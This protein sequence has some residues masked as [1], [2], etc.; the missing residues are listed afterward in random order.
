MSPIMKIPAAIL[1]ALAVLCANQCA[2]E[3]LI[4]LRGARLE[5]V[6]KAGAIDDGILLIRDGKID[7]VGK[8]VKIPVSARIIDVQGATIMPGLVDPYFVVPIGRNVQASETR[9]VVFQG[10]VFVIGGGSPAIATT[11]AKIS[12]GINLS[13]VDWNPARRSGITTLH[14]VTGGYAQSLVAASASETAQIKNPDGQLLVTV[15]NESQS[16]DVLRNGLKEQRSSSGRPGSSSSS[17][18]TSAAATTTSTNTAAST[19]TTTSTG[20][21]ATELWKSVREG[22]SQV[23]VNVNNAAAILHCLAA[24]KE[25]PKATVVFVASGEDIYR[26]LDELDAKTQTIVMSPTI[27][28]LPNSRLR[29]NVPAL[30]AKKKV[31]FA[32]S[33]SLSQSD[34]RSQQQTPL[35]AVGMLVRSGLDRKLALEALTIAPARLLGIEQQVGTLEIGKSADFIVL[36]GDPFAATTSVQRIFT[37]G[38]PIYEN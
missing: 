23:F 13:D 37:A 3:G 16:L 33:L 34:F 30:L 19:S 31:P 12:D 9:T 25:A 15:T 4:A 11:F 36:D 17:A 35:F 18:A 29:V 8:D 28:T 2:A 7:A 10:R 26:T 38:K 27:D 1:M 24:F 5:T 21:S 6:A 20:S 22:K 14:V 32:F